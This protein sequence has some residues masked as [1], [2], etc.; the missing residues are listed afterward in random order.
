MD[1]CPPLS[2]RAAIGHVPPIRFEVVSIGVETGSGSSLLMGGGLDRFDWDPIRVRHAL[3]DL[4]RSAGAF[5][6]RKLCSTI[7]RV[8]PTTAV[9]VATFMDR[10]AAAVRSRTA[11]E[12]HSRLRRPV[13]SSART[14]G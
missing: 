13:W 10:V 2:W 6:L 14:R 8:L 4:G 5:S 7:S 9:T 11:A 12:S 3:R 1:R